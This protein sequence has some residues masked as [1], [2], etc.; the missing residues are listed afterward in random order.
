MPG[1]G[2]EFRA[3]EEETGASCAES[4]ASKTAILRLVLDLTL[5]QWRLFLEV[6]C[7]VGVPGGIRTR[8]IA[9]KVSWHHVFTTT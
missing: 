3:P 1:S 6:L 2:K 5:L 4:P 7:F 8:V 9:V